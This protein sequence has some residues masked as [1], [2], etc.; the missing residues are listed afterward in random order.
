MLGKFDML[1]TLPAR[2]VGRAKRFYEE[3]LGLIPESED[4]GG[5]HYRSGTTMFDIY[6]TEFA[7]SAQHTL[8]GWLVDDI[9]AVV[10][11]LRERGVVFEDYDLPGLRTEGGIAD[12]GSELSAWFKDSEGNILA[13]AELRR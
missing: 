13:I 9:H 7:G 3:K 2:D 8:G 1:L 4:P 10:E 6:P 12:L 11:A 5:V